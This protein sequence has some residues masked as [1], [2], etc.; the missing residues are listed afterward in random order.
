MVEVYA[1]KVAEAE[2]FSSKQEMLLSCLPG[3]ARA[4]IEKLRKTGDFQRSLLGEHLARIVLSDHINIEVNEISFQKSI[5]GKPYLADH[6]N[7]HFNISHSGDWVVVAFSDK[8]VGVDI[9]KIR[10]PQYRVAALFF[11]PIELK[12]LNSFTDR[13][14]EHYFF[15]LW[16]LKESFLKLQGK[17]LTRSLGSFTVDKTTG[18]FDLV[19][20]TKGDGKVYFQQYSIDPLYKLSVCA[21]SGTFAE[22]VNVV[23]FQ[24]LLN[25]IAECKKDQKT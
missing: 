16:T 3:Q 19:K 21:L 18:G 9:E 8:D 5:K 17:G 6:P 23:T 25:K 13:E 11:S 2:A 10:P 1:I 7:I 4:A 22:K 12:R 14:K 20:G 24:D 15:D